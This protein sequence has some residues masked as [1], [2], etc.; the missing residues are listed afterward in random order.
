MGK[1]LFTSSVKEVPP[2]EKAASRFALESKEN[3]EL[4]WSGELTENVGPLRLWG[5][6]V[7]F[8]PASAFSFAD[9]F[10]PHADA[11]S[12]LADISGLPVDAVDAARA[13]ARA[14]PKDTPG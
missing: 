5:V 11:S 4:G 8:L 1:A 3:C 12:S 10:G 7:A 9:G 2:R 14:S 6:C 13:H